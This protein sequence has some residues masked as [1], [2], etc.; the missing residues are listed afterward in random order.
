MLRFLYAGEAVVD[1]VLALEVRPT[2][3][4]APARARRGAC[5]PAAGL[6][7]RAC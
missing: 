1:P 3:P 7:G 6:A 2:R 5:G 4:G